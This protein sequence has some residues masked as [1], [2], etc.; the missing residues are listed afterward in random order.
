VVCLDGSES[1]ATALIAAEFAG[2]LVYLHER[3]FRIEHKT[4]HGLRRVAHD[5]IVSRFGAGH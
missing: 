2:R 3:D 1:D 4:D 5:E